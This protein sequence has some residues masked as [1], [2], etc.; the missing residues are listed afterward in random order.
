MK[1]K[2]QINKF[3]YFIDAYEKDVKKGAYD[4]GGM[5]VKILVEN[6][7]KKKLLKLISQTKGANDKRKF[8][9]LFKEIYNFDLNYKNFNNLLNKR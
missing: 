3:L 5:V 4:E 6:F 7:G 8:A 1:Y 9:K 2:K